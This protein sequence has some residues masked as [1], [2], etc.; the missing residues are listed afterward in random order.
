MLP[1]FVHGVTKG[2]GTQNDIHIVHLDHSLVLVALRASDDAIVV[3][4]RG[5][6]DDVCWCCGAA[7]VITFEITPP[8]VLFRAIFNHIR[9]RL[10]RSIHIKIV[11]NI[12]NTFIPS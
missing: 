9:R 6:N 11:G 4:Q 10:R 5:R 12:N 2:F 8:D 3:W 7:N 1:E